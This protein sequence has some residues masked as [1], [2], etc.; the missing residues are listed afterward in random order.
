[1]STCQLSPCLET[2]C[3][4]TVLPFISIKSASELLLDDTDVCS[5][6]K[7]IEKIAIATITSRTAKKNQKVPETEVEKAVTDGIEE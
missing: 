3:S 4:A 1:M 2:D 7:S 6:Y 5:R